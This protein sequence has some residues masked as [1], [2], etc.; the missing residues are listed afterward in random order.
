MPRPPTLSDDVE[1]FSKAL[2]RAMR[3][4]RQLERGLGIEA[5][6]TSQETLLGALFQR[7]EI[8]VNVVNDCKSRSEVIHHAAKVA[9]ICRQIAAVER[10]SGKDDYREMAE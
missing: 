5:G 7:S 6:T 10:T 2:E 1:W 4:D 3:E 9:N 8:L